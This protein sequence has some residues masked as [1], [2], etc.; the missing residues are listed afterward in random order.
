VGLRY[1][2]VYGPRQDYR[3]AYIAVI[4]KMLDSIDRGEPLV[5]YG[6]GSQSYDFV[7]VKDC[8]AAN[9]CAMKAAAV[10]RFYNVGTGKKTSV[11]ELA[12]LLLEVTGATVGIQHQPGGL[13]F[14]KSRVGS[15]ERAAG[16]IGFKASVELPE[17]LRS[18]VEWR[19]AHKAEV[20]QRRLKGGS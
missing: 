14:V 7:H 19:D 1:M 2:N 12:Q 3:G 10:D 9:V 11:A 13:T 4:M 15:T 18:V 16:E 20:A 8:A 17:G 6:D 5:L